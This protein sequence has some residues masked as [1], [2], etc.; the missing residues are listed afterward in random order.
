VKPEFASL[1]TDE[2]VQ[3]ARQR[4]EHLGSPGPSVLGHGNGSAWAA[5]ARRWKSSSRQVVIS[6]REDTKIDSI[7]T[8][9]KSIEMRTQGNG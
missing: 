3:V 8:R 2:E 4:R 6:A 5:W 9:G 1:C 7:A